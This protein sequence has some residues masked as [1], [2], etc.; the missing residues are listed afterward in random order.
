MDNAKRVVVAFTGVEVNVPD[1]SIFTPEDNLSL[2][3]DFPQPRQID[4]LALS[5]RDSE[6]LI[7]RA[8]YW[9]VDRYNFIRLKVR[10]ENDSQ[11][12][13]FIELKDGSQH[14]LVIPPGAEA[15]LTLFRVS[16]VLVEA[17]VQLT[18]DFDLRKSVHNPSTPGGPYLLRPALRVVNNTQAGTIAGMV[19]AAL[20]PSGCSPAVYVYAGTDV[21]P[22]DAGSATEPLTTAL[23]EMSTGSVTF[24]YRAHFLPAGGY[25]LALT[26]AATTDDPTT[27]DAIAFSEP[28]NATVSAGQIT[29]VNF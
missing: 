2:H 21:P 4:L 7:D 23:V 10:A 27:D 17:R 22:D 13:S 8:P 29:A 11:L 16:G 5:G 14:E 28:Q 24:E 12:D 9:A 26:C 19:D 15:G 18:I 25:T 6:P 20:V 3:V 1:E